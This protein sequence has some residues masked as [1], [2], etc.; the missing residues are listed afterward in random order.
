MKKVAGFACY[1]EI[2]YAVVKSTLFLIQ[3][4]DHYAL[5]ICN[6]APTPFPA[7]SGDFDFWSSK[8]LLK[9]PPLR[10]LIVGKTTAVFPRS[11]L[12]FHFMALF[13]YKNANPGYFPRTAMAKLWS[14]PRSFPLLSPPSPGGGGPWLQMTSALEIGSKKD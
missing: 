9:A 6:Q 1:M 12:S 10:G 11:L 4:Q 8:S 13:A 2:S 14:K 3:C 7:N 5:V